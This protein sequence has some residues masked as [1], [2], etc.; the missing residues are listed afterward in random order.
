MEIAEGEEI[1]SRYLNSVGKEL[2]N[3]EEKVASV[4]LF[5]SL[6]RGD[7]TEMSDVDLLIVFKD[8][9]PDSIITEIDNSLTEIE[10]DYNY[11]K[12]P[13]GILEELIYA[14]KRK[15]GMFVSHF[16]CKKKD[17][18]ETD[19]AKI[20]ST[21]KVMSS[22]IAPSTLVLNN[23]TNDGIILYGKNLIGEFKQPV[24]I[25][26]M[27]KS[28]IMNLMTSIGSTIIAPFYERSTEIS[29]EAL[30][31]SLLASNQYLTEESEGVNEVIRFLKKQGIYSSETLE[32]FK[33]LREKL[34][35]NPV[36]IF[37]VPPMVVKLHL[38]AIKH[39]GI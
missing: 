25:H 21:E 4:I 23:M 22:L 38:Q 32:E 7:N 11:V 37:K 31:W 28:L 1:V 27:V 2:E 34:R 5:G 29:T 20:F 6:A 8:E 24:S 36:F 17:I 33:A 30:K 12:P 19:F 10:K 26:S 16:V 3:I 9:V 13:E 39:R 35:E 18:K 15:T 14:L